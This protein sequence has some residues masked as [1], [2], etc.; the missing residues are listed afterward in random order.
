MRRFESPTDIMHRP[1]AETV[2]A[3]KEYGGEEEWSDIETRY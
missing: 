1:A 2:C 3:R